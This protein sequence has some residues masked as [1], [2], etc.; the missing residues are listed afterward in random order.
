MSLG[1]PTRTSAA[2]SYTVSTCC[3][4]VLIAV[5]ATTVV[6]APVTL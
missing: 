2:P 6:P 4:S 3:A 1:G 5:T